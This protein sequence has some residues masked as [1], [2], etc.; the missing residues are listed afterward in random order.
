MRLDIYFV[1]V[2]IIAVVVIVIVIVIITITVTI[3]VVVVVVVIII[4]ITIIINNREST[5]YLQMSNILKTVALQPRR[6]RVRSPG[7]EDGR[8]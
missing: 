2:I 8:R 5:G 4:I 1:V 6:H 7:G 3:V